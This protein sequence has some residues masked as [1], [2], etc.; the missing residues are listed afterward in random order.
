MS[1][2]RNV[3]VVGFAQAPIVAHDAHR[4]AP[5][6]LYPVVRQ[7]LAQCGSSATRSIIRR[8]ARPITSTAV[9]SA[10]SPRST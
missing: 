1:K 3:A 8:P 9:P 5:E 7:A 6:M 10:S 4:M 2:L